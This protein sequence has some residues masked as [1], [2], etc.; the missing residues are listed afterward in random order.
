MSG[1]W[2]GCWVASGEKGERGQLAGAGTEDGRERALARM[3]PAG[4][5]GQGQCRAPRSK[6]HLTSS[7]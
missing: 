2:G 5:R 3:A 7:V 4:R 1:A 6:I